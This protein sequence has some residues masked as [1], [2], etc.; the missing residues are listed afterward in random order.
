MWLVRQPHGLVAASAL[1][2]EVIERYRIGARLT[3]YI[4][5]QRRDEVLY[6]RYRAIV[7][8]VAKAFGIDHDSLH[9]RLRLKCGLHRELRE[10]DGAVS[11]IPRST[12]ELQDDE[13]RAYFDRAMVVLI[14]E[15]GVPPE[16]IYG[17]DT[18]HQAGIKH[19]LED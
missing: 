4:E 13:F 5:P 18:W 7:S 9:W 8:K 10:L 15:L 14:D 12:T 17:P 11:I 6:R 16:E 1:D 3:C 19:T 2:L